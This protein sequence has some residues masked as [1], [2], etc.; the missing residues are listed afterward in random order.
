MNT[1]E[2]DNYGILQCQILDLII[3]VFWSDFIKQLQTSWM[4]EG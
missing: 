3:M 1:L 2:D 4:M